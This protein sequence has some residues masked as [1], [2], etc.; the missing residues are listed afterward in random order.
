MIIYRSSALVIL[1][2]IF[3]AAVLSAETYEYDDAGRLIKVTWDEQ[4]SITYQYD[5][6]GNIVSIITEGVSGVDDDL[7]TGEENAILQVRTAAGSEPVTID[8]SLP[9]EGEVE[10]SIVDGRGVEVAGIIE[11]SRRAGRLVVEWSARGENQAGLPAGVYFARLRLHDRTGSPSEW[12][13][14][15]VLLR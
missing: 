7:R 14:R 12:I 5:A 10:L 1:A 8:I 15:F 6:A 2:F 9:T 13:C 11:G 3:S 4:R